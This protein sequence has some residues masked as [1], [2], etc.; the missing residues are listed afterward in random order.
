VCNMLHSTGP[1]SSNLRSAFCC[2]QPV[3]I[4]SRNANLHV[5]LAARFATI[6]CAAA[7]SARI[8]CDV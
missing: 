6:F 1:A 5:D 3:M 4:L 2:A 7:G 8:E